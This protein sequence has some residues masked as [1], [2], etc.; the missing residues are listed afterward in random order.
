M[1][2]KKYFYIFS[3]CTILTS[4]AKPTDCH[5]K[6]LIGAGIVATGCIL[7]ALNSEWTYSETYKRYKHLHTQPSLSFDLL[8]QEILNEHELLWKKIP[9]YKNYPLLCFNQQLSY[10]ISSLEWAHAFAFFIGRTEEIQ[11]LLDQLKDIQRLLTAN[12]AF[13]QERRQFDAQ[14]THVVVHHR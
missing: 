8:V 14:L 1:V 4:T 3:V 9:E 7:G 2:F 6:L 11:Y 5:N 10:D 13:I 12:Y